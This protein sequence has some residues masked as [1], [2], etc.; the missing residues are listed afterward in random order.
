[1]GRSGLDAALAAVIVPDAADTA[2]LRV[3]LC[4]GD[5]AR[6]AWVD[7]CGRI[8]DPKT[9]LEREARGLKGLLP[10]LHEAIGREDLEASPD[11]RTYLKAAR[12]R[13]ELRLGVILR[14]LEQ[15]LAALREVEVPHLLVGG[16]AAAF[17]CHPDP[18][19]R[20]VHDIDLLVPRQAWPA[21]ARALAPLGFAA[22]RPGVLRHRDGLPLLLHEDLVEHPHHGLADVPP[23]RVVLPVGDGAAAVGPTSLLVAALARGAARPDRTNLRWACDAWRLAA[24][25]AVDW[26]LLEQ[27]ISRRRMA[28]A[29]APL[30]RHVA[31][32]LGAALPPTVAVEL[33]RLAAAATPLDREAALDAAITGLTSARRALAAADGARGRLVRFVLWPSP[34]RLAWRYGP[35]SPPRRLLQRIT[36]P[37]RYVAGRARRRVAG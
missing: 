30:A 32:S 16:V 7:W 29:A 23:D 31:D 11:L 24:N 28:V 8:G 10:L 4:P 21:A 35:A 34:D 14:L 22:E 33:E 1:M 26:H 9:Y 36:R 5:A 19:A 15:A 17:V 20:H 27:E 13:E 25:G 2:L 12:L 18:V 37:L 3:C 6:R